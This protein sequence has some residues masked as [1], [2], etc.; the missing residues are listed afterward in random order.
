MGDHRARIAVA[1]LLAAWAVLVA[2]GDQGLPIYS[3]IPTY[4]VAGGACTGL[5]IQVQP[6]AAQ[7]IHWC[8]IGSVWVDCSVG[9]EGATGA[10]QTN[11]GSG[12]FGAFGGASCASGYF[13]TSMGA[14]GVWGCSQVD[15][16]QLTGVPATFPPSA[17]TH[18]GTDVTSAVANATAAAGLSG[19]TGTPS[20]S[21]FLRG[22]WSWQMPPAQD[23]E[24]ITGKPATFPATVPVATASALAANGANC[25]AG[26]AAAGVDAGGASEGCFVPPGTYVLPDATA[27]VTGGVRLT[28]DLG[29]T[30]VA[31]TVPGLAGKAN[32]THA[33]AAGDVTS[34]VLAG[35]QGGG[36]A[37]LP[38]CTGTDKLTANGTSWTCATDQTASYTLPAATATVLGGVKGTGSALVCSGTDKATGFAADGSLQC[39]SDQA[40]AYVLPDATASV[41]GGIRLTGDLGGTATSPTVPA[42]ANVRRRDANTT[43]TGGGR[44][45]SL[46]GDDYAY[47]FG[48]VLSPQSYM[49]DAFQF[50]P[51]SSYETFDGTT[52]TVGSI[53]PEVFKGAFGRNWS[54]HSIPN[55]TA[56]VR[57]TWNSVNYVIFSALLME[58]ATLGSTMD[59]ELQGS[60]DGNSWTSFGSQTGF[61]SW[62]G[63]TVLSTPGGTTSGL[64][65][66]R[67]LITPHWAGGNA[68][69]IGQIGLL[70]GYGDY[71]PLYTWDSARTVSFAGRVQ[72]GSSDSTAGADWI[73]GKY[74]SGYGYLGT[75]FGRVSSGGPALGYGLKAGT[76]SGNPYLS[77][78]GAFIARSVLELNGD[79]V[80]FS[81]AAAQNTP[82]GLPV[83]VTERLRISSLGATFDSSVTSGGK[84]SASGAGGFESTH[85]VTGAR[86]PIW[87]F[88]D[89]DGYG[90]SYF[91]G[92]AGLNGDDT[93]GIHMGTS[94]SAGSQWTFNRPDSSFRSSGRIMSGGSYV[95][96]LSPGAGGQ[97]WTAGPN[98]FRTLTEATIADSSTNATLQAASSAGGAAYM[99][100]HRGGYYAVNFGLDTDNKLRVG[101]WSMGAVSY[102]IL[103]ERDI[104]RRVTMSYNVYTTTANGGVAGTSWTAAANTN[105][106]LDCYLLGS[107]TSTSAPRVGFTKT[108]TV[109]VGLNAQYTHHL[110]SVASSVYMFHP[111]FNGALTASCTSGCITDVIPFRVKALVTIGN[112]TPTI[113]VALHSSTG[114]QMVTLLAGST[115]EVTTL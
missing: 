18:A 31:P 19:T 112:E 78:T 79:Q 28:G 5:R 87:R 52:W 99:A 68:I 111:V 15:W 93:I 1:A 46:A 49:Q 51:P 80:V 57:M 61:S 64:T 6:G 113:Y 34:G 77:S 30:A 108:G 56:Q 76:T 23:W 97:D 83:P 35:A 91:Q 8:C 29:G 104:P 66:L 107:G 48:G 82:I 59:V 98:Y 58:H 16:A 7:A 62:P 20:T 81:T 32:T 33:H 67:V 40:S 12:S 41:T 94:T 4:P 47:T 42:L 105:Y 92:T 55:G 14:S 106:S 44:N 10:I 37:A 101:G 85:F 103:D 26:E 72:L 88:G 17:H 109:G 96:V 9:P 43:F 50:N 74:T 24:G 84:V 100:F 39:A 102:R 53:S 36:G 54:I 69:T 86:N 25:A 73:Y 21:T 114:G 11:A 45:L 95:P 70:A 75:M 13:P 115:C 60:V 2:R 27:A 90:L 38:T 110:T 71:Q 22:D 63:A 89:A 3:A 65:Y